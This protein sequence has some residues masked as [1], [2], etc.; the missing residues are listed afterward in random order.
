MHLI[1]VLRGNPQRGTHLTVKQ[2]GHAKAFIQRAVFF[3]VQK[4]PR[5]VIRHLNGAGIHDEITLAFLL[6]GQL[7]RNLL[8][9]TPLFHVR[10][11]LKQ[12]PRPPKQRTGQIL[13]VGY[14]LTASEGLISSS[15][16]NEPSIISQSGLTQFLPP[17]RL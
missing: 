11:L 12:Q 1:V 7:R 14:S 4:K 5:S 13:V 9:C 17:L 8:Q 6:A 3:M 2:P 15:L 10:V 16:R